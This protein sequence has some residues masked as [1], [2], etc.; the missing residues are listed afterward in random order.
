MHTQYD[1]DTVHPRRNSDCSKWDKTGPGVLP[2]WVA[3]MDFRSPPEVIEALEE[4][5]RHG[6]FGYPYFGSQ[7]QEAVANW[8]AERHGWQID[9]ASVVLVPGVVT[10]FNLATNAVARAGDSVLVQTPTYGPFLRVAKNFRL[11][12]Q[13]MQLTP[14]PDGQYQLDLDAFEAAITPETR[15]FMLCNPQNPTG[16]VFSRQELEGMA[17]ICLRHGVT[18]C[19]DEIHSDLI[20][21]GYK[22]LPIASLDRSI[23]DQTITLIA[24][25]KTFN[26]AGLNASIAIIENEDLRKKYNQARQ[27]MVG[28]VNSLGT[29][30]LQAAYQ[31]GTP[32]LEALLAYLEENRDLT[33]QHVR[34]H[35]PGVRIAAPQG[36]YLAWLDC[37]ELGL[38]VKPG[39]EFNPFFLE[40]AKVA[41]NEGSWFGAGGSGFA[42][43]NFGCPR[44]TLLEALDRMATALQ[45]AL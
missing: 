5:V 40:H 7:V 27:G 24:P 4:A 2:L 26:T 39:A 31:H 33:V 42:R 43:L 22:H 10:G 11:T 38:E 18:I 8:V 15:I 13:E 45:M 36:T 28:F 32:W 3:D 9:P 20:Y 6:I 44:S 21:S 30:A 19:A 1:F 37:R 29:L 34:Q 25:S 41:L 16:R 35:L 12:Q 14:G 23:S 17:E